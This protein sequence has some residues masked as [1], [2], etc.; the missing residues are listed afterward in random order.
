MIRMNRIICLTLLLLLSPGTYPQKPEIQ[1]DRISVKEG[2]TDHSI[3]CITQDHTGF[4]WIGGANGLYRYDGYEVTS[5]QYQ[6]GDKVCQYFKEIYRIREDRF[7]LLWIVSEMGIV[8]YDP[9]VG[10]ATLLELYTSEKRSNEFNYY[11]DILID[12]NGIIWATYRNGLIKISVKED[13]GKFMKSDKQFYNVENSLFSTEL[14]ELPF[15]GTGNDNYVTRIMEDLDGNIIAGCISGLF[16]LNKVNNSLVRINSGMKSGMEEDFKYV[17]SIV[18][19]DDSTYWV[20]SGNY[21]YNLSNLTTA[22]TQERSDYSF[23][24]FSRYSLGENQTPTSLFVDH[25]GNIYA[26]TAQGIFRI[27]KN[28]KDGRM[29]FSL[30]D[31]NENDPEY[32]GYTKTISDIFED[33]SGVIWTAQ[34]YYGIT[35]FNPGRSRFNSYK[36]LIVEN[37]RS[38]DVN[39]IFRDKKGNLW[40]GTYGGGLY[41]MTTGTYMIS[42]YNLYMQ[43]NNILCI[44]EYKPGVFMIGSDR[45]VVEFDAMSGK[46]GDPASPALKIIN[47]NEIYI[48][49]IVKD[50]NFFYIASNGGLFIFDY[51]KGSLLHYNLVKNDSLPELKNQVLSLLR[52]HNGDVLAGTSSQGIYKIRMKQSGPEI[53]Q[54]TDSKTLSDNGIFLDRRHRLFEDSSGILWITDYMGLHSFD[55]ARSEFRHYK[56]FE[57]INFPVAWSITEDDRD[58]LWIGTHFGLC[59]FNKT[60]GNVRIYGKEHGLPITIHGLNSV[61]KDETGRL[62]FG[63]I[64]GFYDFHPD[65]LRTNNAIPPVVITDVL[66]SNVSLKG[67]SDRTSSPT[68]DMP[69]VNFI[70]LKYYQNDLTIK[71]SSL[72]YNQPLNNQY[73]YRLEGYHEQWISA[74]AE[75]RTASYLK[76]KPGSYL[77]R[78]KG[79]NGDG[80]WND[81]GASLE[82]LIK[83]PWWITYTALA[84]Y[85]LAIL[86]VIRGFIRWR[87]LKL[88][89]ERVELEDLVRIRTREITEQSHKISEQK[90][91]LEKQNIKIREEEELKNRFF[92][93]ISHE[94]RT[95]LS[96]IKSPAEELLDKS[97]L[98]EKE[99]R[100]LNMINRNAQRLLHLVNQLLDLSKF[101]GQRME[102]EVSEGDV[103][104]L[105]NNI[106]LSFTSAA[107]AKS[108]DFRCTFDGRKT[109]TWSDH[110]KIEKIA[111][112][113]LANAF[114]FTP[115]GGEIEFTAKYLHKT[116]QINTPFLEFFVKDSGP[117][118]P[119]KSL[120]RIFD[121]FYQ[122]DENS[123][124]NNIGTGIGL[125]LALELTK[126]MHGEI[127]VWSQT[128]EGSVFTVTIP[129]GKNH[130]SENEYVV[131]SRE[132]DNIIQ[133]ELIRPAFF[134]EEEDQTRS[135]KEDK[136]KPVL[137]I[138]DDNRDL[139]NQLFE[140][141]ESAY[142]VKSAVDGVAGLK[143]A[144]EIIPDLIVTDLMMPK[145]DGMELCRQLK[146]NEVTAHIPVIMLTARDTGIDKVNGLQAGADDYIAKPFSMTELKARIANLIDQRKKLRE[147]FSREIVL[148][149]SE[150]TVT[151]SDEKFLTRAISLIEEHMKDEKFTS[152]EFNRMMNMSRSTLF[153]KISALTGQSP[154]EFIR[155]IR[156]K[157]A[158]ELIGKKF[159]NIS[160]VAAETGF[161]NISY[162]NRSFKKLYGISPKEFAEK[163]PK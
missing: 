9:Q 62:W 85:L 104:I 33:R 139:R 93:N 145:M 26:G 117:G 136:S 29:V 60:T 134:A 102:L 2:L 72:D 52:L 152:D 73:L 110:D 57:K 28:E 19:A 44:N 103:M 16:V 61:F 159:G 35:K 79:S 98:N 125:S 124:A 47:Q 138:I 123:G 32:Y 99:R 137:L 63:G 112:N 156:L 78:V 43:K 4:I 76:L 88:K 122:V 142:N 163:E 18:Q 48:W 68:L 147:R 39:P 131:V 50:N 96:L 71:F 160:E 12:R 7:G 59:R 22:Q 87:L 113:I 36:S 149:P 54:V 66:L 82:I 37:F 49:D 132:Q 53:D 86:L 23:G 94:F 64:G 148:E 111:T 141:L 89:R 100:K 6:P 130:L 97:N 41:K 105:L 38:T 115:V 140:N 40:I 119:E 135:G 129:L 14:I 58:N 27:T 162:F 127:K 10:R 56:L 109:V 143:K 92:T 151:S 158:A 13:P 45:G 153:R 55:F 17:R 108:I 91:L 21:I 114:K 20:A 75:N 65:S 133:P 116:D 80:V 90:E 101:D 67:R 5:Y 1:L 128:D 155:T 161:N 154:S 81:E 15:S 95:P 84:G 83:K 157:R 31:S 42:H 121:R 120:G 46:S 74:D 11:P 69:Y 107:E 25:S 3:Y 106:T 24:R 30:L 77:F 126:L 70:K 118:I 8:L 34:D 144:L 51:R 146:G 150:I